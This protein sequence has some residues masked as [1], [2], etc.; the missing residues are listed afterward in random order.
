MGYESRLYVV[1]KTLVCGL[2]GRPWYETIAIFN[3]GKVY[4]V[5]NIMTKY[6]E[7]KGFV[8]ADDGNTEIVEDEYGSA[9]KEVPLKDAIEIIERANDNIYKRYKPCLMLLKA[10]KEED[11]REIVVLHFGY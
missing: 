5:S 3:L 8:F 1:N 4:A 6:P 11:W 10:F 2:S 7:T 9:L